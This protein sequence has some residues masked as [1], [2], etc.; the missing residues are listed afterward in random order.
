MPQKIKDNRVREPKPWLRI[1]RDNKHR[2]AS[3][4]WCLKKTGLSP[5]QFVTESSGNTRDKSLE[6]YHWLSFYL[7][8]SLCWK[9]DPKHHWTKSSFPGIHIYYV[10]QFHAHI[11]DLIASFKLHDWNCPYRKR[12]GSRTFKL[13]V[14]RKKNKTAALEPRFM[15]KKQRDE[16]F[17]ST[18]HIIRVSSKYTMGGKTKC[19]GLAPR[20]MLKKQRDENL[21]STVH[22]IRVSSNPWWGKKNQVGN[23]K[24][25]SRITFKSPVIAEKSKGL[26]GTPASESSPPVATVAAAAAA[27]AVVF[28]SS[29]GWEDATFESS[30]FPVQSQEQRTSTTFPSHRHIVPFSFRFTQESSNTT[31][32]KRKHKRLQLTGGSGHGSDLLRNRWK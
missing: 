7:L 14:A 23:K 10:I 2:K 12:I 15:L 8:A 22:L 17:L 6:A 20:V 5:S 26:G 18:V 32:E 19:L 21:L 9:M 4:I 1:P 30:S 13:S 11:F 31:T 3:L 24:D 29:A 28:S 25:C 27:A 16:I